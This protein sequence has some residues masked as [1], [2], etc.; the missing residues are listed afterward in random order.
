MPLVSVI[1]PTY[2]RWPWLRDA[3]DS[4]LAQSFRDFELIIVDDGSEDGTHQYLAADYSKLNGFLYLKHGGVSRARNAGFKVARGDW[5]AFLDSDDYWLP[6]KLGRQIEFLKSHEDI[7]VCYTDE[8]WIRHGV[9]VNPM[10]KHRKYSGW[11]FERCLPLCLISPSAVILRRE[12]FEEMGGFDESLPVC[13][14]YDL[15]LRITCVYP[16]AFLEEKLIVK[17]GGHPDQL[18]RSEWGMD[19]F[20]VQAIQNILAGG[21]L[22]QRQEIAALQELVIK[23]R[24]LRQGCSKRDR[25]GELKVYSQ[26]IQDAESRLERITG[27]L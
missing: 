25:C 26:L 24:I 8:I 7:S 4:V 18:S 3:L 12:L 11:V 14:D 16:V 5:I 27:S 2:N 15:W 22:D 20:R 9:R 6:G 23:C 13:E 21:K 19:R 1:I 17:R 10:N